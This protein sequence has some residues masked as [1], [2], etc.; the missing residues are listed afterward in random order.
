MQ[1]ISPFQLTDASAWAGLTTENHLGYMGMQNRVLVNPLIDQIL[2]VNLGMDFDRFMDNFPVEYI[3]SDVEF[4]WLLCGPDIKNYPLVTYYDASG[5]TPAKPGI[6]GSRF[7]MEFPVRMFE[8]TD[9]IATDSK[10]IYQLQVKSDPG[11]SGTNWK[12]EVELVTGDKT[13]FV[14]AAELVVGKRFAKLYSPVE[15]TLSQRGGTVTHSGYFKMYNRCSTIRSQYDVPGNMINAKQNPAMGAMFTVKGPDGKVRTEATWLGK[16]D[17]DFMTQFKRQ[18]AYLGMYAIHNKN[19]QNTYALKGESGYEIKMGAGL[20]QQISPTNVHYLNN[21]TIEQL[22]DILLSLSVGKLPEDQ[23]KFVIATGEYGWKRFHELVEATGIPFSANNAGGRITGSGNKLRFGG[24]FT[25]LGL[26]NGIEVELMKLPFLDDPTL[27][28]EIHPD[29]GLVSSYEMLIMDIGTTKGKPN[30]ARMM[31][32]GEEE[33][34][35][36]VP[37][38]RDPFAPNGSD[39]KPKLAMSGKD[40]YQVGKKYTAGLKVNNPTKIARILPNFH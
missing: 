20:Y 30:V 28:T 6:N 16:L 1:R 38:I 18:K 29:G 31:V 25:S 11:M 12:Y 32:K 10:E 15:Q 7:Y 23:R 5:A 17:Y 2:E 13:L 36:Y 22:E 33:L 4:D 26:V 24:Q 37:G 19:E 9:V 3:D 27:N 39:S 34:T 40:G 8:A 14:P 21:Y 35:Y